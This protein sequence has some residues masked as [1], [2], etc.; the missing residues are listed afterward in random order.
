MKN[1][2]WKGTSPVSEAILLKEPLLAG[3][4]Y[5]TGEHR[6]FDYRRMIRGEKTSTRDFLSGY[7]NR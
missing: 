2:K 6:Y 5:R 1:K 4:T 7:K 3:S